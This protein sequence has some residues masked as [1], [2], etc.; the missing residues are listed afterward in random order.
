M[1]HP[2]R[3]DG[4][5]QP[6]PVPPRSSVAVVPP[7]RVAAASGEA[8][9]TALVALE[10]VPSEDHRS[11]GWL[12]TAVTSTLASAAVHLALLIILGLV[13]AI[14]HFGAEAISLNLLEPNAAV[15]EDDLL[16]DLDLPIE[17]ADE[18]S[19]P[20]LE[21]LLPQGPAIDDAPPQELTRLPRQTTTTLSS[22]GLGRRMGQNLRGD[23]A[24]RGLRRRS[25]LAYGATP[26]SENAVKLALEWIVRHQ[27]TD[28]SWSFHH[29]SGDHDCRSCR[30]RN[31]GRTKALNGAT[32]MG[33]LPLLGAGNSHIEGRYRTEV[34]AGLR[35]LI[36]HQQSNGSLMDTHG[37]MYSHGLATLALCE[38]LAMA[39]YYGPSPAAD[40]R[41][42]DRGEDRP[43]ASSGGVSRLVAQ[44]SGGSDDMR[45]ADE[46]A[47]A[48]SAV[49]LADLTYAAQ[50]AVSFIES[51]QHRA[52]GWRYRP[53]QA[54]DT[55]VVGWQMMALK[56]GYLAG[57]KVDP[58]VIPRAER[59]LNAVAY[60]K[61]GSCYGYQRTRT[62]TEIAM[63]SKVKA[64]TP[65]GLL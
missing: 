40:V 24:G 46:L 59:F 52:G 33:L 54:G 8:D 37:N 2:S 45:Q 23:L 15:R 61:I 7:P 1:A 49:N 14:S 19:L 42:A 51:A 53:R 64:T 28:G 25:A 31:P 26:E 11:D 21:D 17:L 4:G 38:A 32:A 10:D 41:V 3:D 6:P 39:R 44:R 47:A 60:D 57:L 56:S 20:S 48:S 55:S 22:S 5:A 13:M 16:E 43:A 12:L 65:I 62:K 50:Q 18:A 58:R 34:S 9:S 29:Q 27:R 35:Y 30:C 63:T 36:R